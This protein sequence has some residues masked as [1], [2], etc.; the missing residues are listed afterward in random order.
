MKKYLILFACT[1]PILFSACHNKTNNSEETEI[2]ADVENSENPYISATQA[3]D[4]PVLEEDLSGNIV[5]LSASEFIEKITEIDNPKGFSYKGKTPCIVDFN[6]SWCGPCIQ[7]KPVVEQLA[8]EYKGRLIIYSVN[9]DKAQDIC[10]AL[11]ITSIPALVFFSKTNQ[12]KKM[13]GYV[14]KQELKSA[15]DDYLNQ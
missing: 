7:L 14:S 3:A 2:A 6:A 15:I 4:S 8:K 10:E 9:V 12:P 1:L 5:Y 13:I 11:D